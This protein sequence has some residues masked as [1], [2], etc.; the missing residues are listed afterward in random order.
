MKKP[1]IEAAFGRKPDRYP[2]WF[3]RQAGRYLPEY[4]SV[5]SNLSFLELCRSPE[6]ASEIT[7]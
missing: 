6:K 4:Q 3:L 5:R 2:I 1:L 7:L